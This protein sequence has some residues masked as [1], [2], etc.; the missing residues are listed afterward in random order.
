MKVI[1]RNHLRPLILFILLF[2]SL[3]MIFNASAQTSFKSTGSHDGIEVIG[4]ATVEVS[5]ISLVKL[6]IIER[7]VTAHKTSLL[8]KQKVNQ[9]INGLRALGV[10]EQEIKMSPLTMNTVYDSQNTHL[11]NVEVF[12]K[13]NGHRIKVNTKTSNDNS[14]YYEQSNNKASVEAVRYITVELKEDDIYER[15]Y[16]DAT[17]RGASKITQESSAGNCE[18]FYE[19]ALAQALENAKYKAH[20]LALK[21][22]VTL[23]DVVN[24]KELSDNSSEL[25]NAPHIS[26]HS[27]SDSQHAST[28][29]AE[30]K[31]RFKIK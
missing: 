22:N 15:L 18:I 31:V 23:G 25:S 26:S 29:S 16:D 13:R 7:G 21:M 30:V 14:N 8:V 2:I 12:D 10:N 20:D 5:D 4:K 11:G 19:K 17:K 6:T 1:N 27:R 3:F 9:V 24:I 28:V